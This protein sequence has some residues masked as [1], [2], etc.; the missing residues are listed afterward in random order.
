MVRGFV[1]SRDEHGV[2]ADCRFWR[3]DGGSSWGR[4]TN[5]RV[6][7]QTDPNLEATN[8]NFGCRYHEEQ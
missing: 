3:R 2:C 5:P 8:Q 7:E 4:C 1:E 6:H